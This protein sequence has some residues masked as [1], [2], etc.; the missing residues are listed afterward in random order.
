MS[1][2]TPLY[3]VK[4]Q[5][6]LDLNSQVLTGTTHAKR[7]DVKTI[8]ASNRTIVVSDMGRLLQFSGSRTL[9]FNNDITGITAGDTFIATSDAALN[10]AG[11][12]T[13]HNSFADLDQNSISQF[14]Y[15]GSNTWFK[16]NIN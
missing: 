3:N 9:T 8:G 4:L 14:I 15:V 6:S 16:L 1:S 7:F 12:A 2:I 11:A 5:S 10:I 13:V